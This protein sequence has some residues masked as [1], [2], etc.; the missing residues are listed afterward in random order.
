MRITVINGTEKHGVTYRLKEIFLDELRD[1]S[2]ITEFYAVRMLQTE[3]GKKDPEYT[4]YRYWKDNG[5]LDKT[6][7]WK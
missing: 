5:W 1:M 4:D 2:E 7:P 3:L 6:R